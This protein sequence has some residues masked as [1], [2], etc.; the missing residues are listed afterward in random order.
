MTKELVQLSVE[1]P[2]ARLAEVRAILQSVDPKLKRA[3][4]K[5]LRQGLGEVADNIV[6]DFPREA[7]LS[8][9]SARWGRVSAKVV[10]N[11]MAKPGRALATISVSGEPDFAR[12][13]S[14]TER[15]GS[16]SSGFTPYGQ[17]MISN[18]R[19]GLQERFP[20]DGKGGRFVFKA[21]RKQLPQAIA[22]AMASIDKFIDKFNRSS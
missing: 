21:F 11:S 16:R 19:G 22:V 15:A 3:M 4:A 6:S 13:L 2:Q 20:L 18:P 12:L 7:P 1:I 14:I 9:M 17:A 5:D 10:T 8:G